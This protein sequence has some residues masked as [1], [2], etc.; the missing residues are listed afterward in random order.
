M[1]KDKNDLDNLNMFIEE[2]QDDIKLS[3]DELINDL[4]AEI[5]N[6]DDTKE[7][8][9]KIDAVIGYLCTRIVLGDYDFIKNNVMKLIVEKEFEMADV[10]VSMAKVILTNKDLAKEFG[11]NL[12]KDNMHAHNALVNIF[13]NERVNYL[14]ELSLESL[15][16]PY[17]E[18]EEKDV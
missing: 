18:E 15:L 6:E 9:E 17:S 10:W 13:I 12:K 5:V 3:P 7:A 4:I 1:K 11:T 14:K 8:K 2:D 16:I